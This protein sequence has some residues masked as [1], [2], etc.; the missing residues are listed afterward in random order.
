MTVDALRTRN[1]PVFLMDNTSESLVINVGTQGGLKITP[2]AVH[3][4]LGLPNGGTDPPPF[5]YAHKMFV[6]MPKREEGEEDG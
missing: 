3:C 4:V 6:E 5:S 1:L 2:H